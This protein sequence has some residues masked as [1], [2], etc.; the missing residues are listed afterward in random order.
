MKSGSRLSPNSCAFQASRPTGES[1]SAN[2]SVC[3]C[4]LCSTLNDEHVVVEPL[5]VLPARPCRSRTEP[6]N[7]AGSPD[8]NEN[9]CV[10]CTPITCSGS[11]PAELRRDHR[12]GVVADRA[13]PLVAEAAHQLGPGPGG[14]VACSSRRCGSGPEKPKPG[15][16]GITRWNAGASGVVG[17]GQRLDDVQVLHDRAGP[18]V[19]Q[20][21]RG[22]VGPRRPDVQE[23]DVLAVD[24]GDELRVGV[25]P[26]LDRPPVEAVQPVRGQLPDP[27]DWSRRRRRPRP[28][29][30]S[31]T[32]VRRSRV[33]QVVQRG[34]RDV[35]AERADLLSTSMT[36]PDLERNASFRS[37]L[38]DRNDPFQW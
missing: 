2:A 22:G 31:A 4:W 11:M 33:A 10:T 21:Q 19:R 24:L 30:R 7:S 23:V 1:A 14:A 12:S 32:R 28:A 13:V 16:D 17:L 35:D 5:Q 8:G 9:S 38:T 3:G 6:S 18:A 27:L 34:L 20:D 26:R 15:S 37:N 36:P 29:A 25:E